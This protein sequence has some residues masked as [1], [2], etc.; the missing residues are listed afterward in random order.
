MYFL[1]LVHRLTGFFFFNGIMED[2]KEMLTSALK[3]NVSN[4]ALHLLPRGGGKMFLVN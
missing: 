1:L 3:S 4:F 2:E